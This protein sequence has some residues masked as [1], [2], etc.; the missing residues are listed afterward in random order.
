LMVEGKKKSSQV[1]GAAK[2]EPATEK[3][4]PPISS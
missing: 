2:T 3:Q 4:Q 1:N